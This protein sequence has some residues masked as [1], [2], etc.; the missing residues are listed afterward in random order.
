MRFSRRR[1][2]A[3]FGLV[4]LFLSTASATVDFNGC[5]TQG[6]ARRAWVKALDRLK[7]RDSAPAPAQFN[8]AAT[9]PAMLQ[10]GDDRGRWK[11]KDAAEMVGYVWDVKPGGI[12]SCNC[13]A[14]AVDDRDTHIELVLNPMAGAAAKRF[15]VE[16]TPRW[17]AAM[18]AKGVD[19]RTRAL[20]D[21]FKGRWVRVQGWLLLDS[22]HLNA[23]ENTAPGRPR[24]WRATAWEVHPVTAIDVVAQPP[25]P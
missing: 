15:I 11:A 23:A 3:C 14:K 24:N 21:H 8:R 19:W 16:V 1:L 2:L 4:S 17:R 18:A 20:R 25:R 7:N 9:L 22:E 10:P 13:H 12:E 6:D 5:P